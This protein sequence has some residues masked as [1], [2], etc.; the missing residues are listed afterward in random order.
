LD[1]SIQPDSSPSGKKLSLKALFA[2][3]REKSAVQTSTALLYVRPIVLDDFDWLEK[4]ASDCPDD[5]SLGK[6]ALSRLLTGSADPDDREPLP[7]TELAAPLP[8][9]DLRVIVE[10]IAMRNDCGAAHDGQSLQ[11]LGQLMRAV[12][13]KQRAG[14]KVHAEQM[15]AIVKKAFP[16]I[17]ISIRDVLKSQIGEIDRTTAQLKSLSSLGGRDYTASIA[18]LA[19]TT[20]P[21]PAMPRD[22]IESLHFSAP[23][24]S[25]G[26]SPLL[27][28]AAEAAE[29]TAAHIESLATPLI[30]RA[31]QI[32]DLATTL[33]TSVL[34]AW[35]EQAVA[36][37]RDSEAAR[38]GS[39]RS[40]RVAM[41][42][43]VAA[44]IISVLLAVAQYALAQLDKKETDAQQAETAKI[45]Q[46]Q[47][48]AV[49]KMQAQMMDDAKL[50]REAVQAQTAA[51]REGS[52]PKPPKK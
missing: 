47:L 15:E 49:Q 34:P 3:A 2:K 44:G 41:W 42:T 43:A 51:I 37:R 31:I 20:L 14:V 11:V 46:A 30:E 38:A 5:E 23:P 6:I 27:V 50:L 16:T 45:Q 26:P 22:G 33:T 18:S 12:I 19:N 36:A 52:G 35:Q 32:G 39:E 29:Q 17:P 24:L 40:I 13:A 1:E 9:A 4:A 25:M 10:A 48:Q 8:E 7:D 28:R 21:K